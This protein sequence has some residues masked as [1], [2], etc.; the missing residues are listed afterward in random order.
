MLALAMLAAAP[1]ANVK[2]AAA[3]EHD[4]GKEAGFLP[5]IKAFSRVFLQFINNLVSFRNT[6][7]CNFEL[8]IRKLAIIN[9]LHVKLSSDFSPEVHLKFRSARRWFAEHH[10]QLAC[11]RKLN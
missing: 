1:L 10:R 2:L 7:R 5:K 11:Y 6:E 3:K 8:L 9:C 4:N